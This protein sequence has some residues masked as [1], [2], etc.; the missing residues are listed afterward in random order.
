M[1]TLIAVMLLTSLSVAHAETATV[2]QFI[3]GILSISEKQ[4]THKGVLEKELADQQKKMEAHAEKS[5][6][7]TICECVPNQY[8]KLKSTLSKVELQTEISDTDFKAKYLPAVINPCAAAQLKATYADGC[9]ERVA[10]FRPN[11]VN[12]CSCILRNLSTLSDAEIAKLGRDSADYTPML[13]D[14]KN[15]G[16]TPPEQPETVKRFAAMDASCINE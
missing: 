11:S 4:C 9:A 12:Y 15:R 3:N 7:K 13:E 5:A 6:E 8:K 2:D 14:A 1:K 10:Q 16:L